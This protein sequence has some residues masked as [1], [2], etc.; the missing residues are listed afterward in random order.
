MIP[1]WQTHEHELREL[2]LADIIDGPG[3]PVPTLMLFDGDEPELLVRARVEGDR[4]GCDHLSEMATIV[5]ASQVPRAVWAIPGRARDLSCPGDDGVV[6]HVL[7]CSSVEYREDGWHHRV[8]TLPWHPDADE[9]AFGPAMDV[10][11]ELSPVAGLLDDALRHPSGHDPIGTLSVLTAWGHIVATPDTGHAATAG[12]PSLPPPRSRD[13]HQTHR[14][15][16]E[17]SRRYRP[18]APAE[19]ARRRPAIVTDIPPGWEPACP[20]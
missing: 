19:A 4:D 9:V 7:V 10:E 17:L 8:R 11:V 12:R 3:L 15:A 13:R 1:R 16:L 5:A 18:T 2:A 20:L 6:A 14:L